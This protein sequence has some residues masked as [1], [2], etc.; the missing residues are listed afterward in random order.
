MRERAIAYLR[1]TVNAPPHILEQAIEARHAD[2]VRQANAARLATRATPQR[3][4]RVRLGAWL[5]H[6]PE[7]RRRHGAPV[8]PPA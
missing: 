7:P 3:R 1:M 2:L 5:V 4:F 8:R 6:T